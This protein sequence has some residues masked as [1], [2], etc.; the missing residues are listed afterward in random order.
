MDKEI[1][2][3]LIHFPDDH[4]GQVWLGQGQ[5]PGAPRALPR[6]GQDPSTWVAFPDALSGSWI[7]S[8]AAQTDTLIWH[9]GMP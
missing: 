6:G 3:P 9:A 7:G 2:H 4:N 5:N 8:W 1:I